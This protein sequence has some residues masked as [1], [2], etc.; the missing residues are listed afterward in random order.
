MEGM[1]H[2]LEE[3]VAAVLLSIHVELLLPSNCRLFVG[4]GIKSEDGAYLLIVHL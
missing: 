2:G 1:F 4:Q 3:Q